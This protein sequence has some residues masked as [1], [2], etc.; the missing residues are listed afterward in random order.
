MP[1]KIAK[2]LEGVRC[3]R[4]SVRRALLSLK[5]MPYKD[6]GFAKIDNHRV[7]RRGFPEVVF[8]RGKTVGQIV[9]ISKRII[10]QDGILLVT[11]APKGAYLM[12]KRAYPKVRYD[13]RAACL[14]YRKE[15]PALKKGL[16]LVITAGTAD[17]PVAEEARIT[18]EL[19]GNPVKILCDVGVAG[20]HRILN[21]RHILDKANIIIVIAGM[22]GA[23][24]SVVSGLVSK[25][26]I[27]VP[28]SIGYGA[29]FE[30][31]AP[32][33]TMMNSCSPGVSVVNIDNGFGA[34][35]FASLI[36]T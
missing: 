33:L 32:L 27:A 34:G 8:G 10:A 17:L 23:L 2:T 14:Y 24:A 12:L 11:R 9:A 21:K 1:E 36:N 25:P 4:I 3:G 35:Y 18:L 15:R 6:I 29:S 7:L 20:I 30:G 16:V 13:D 22:E 19:M 28:T 31:I 5:D 26:V